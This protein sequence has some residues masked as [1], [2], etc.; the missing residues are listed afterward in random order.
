MSSELVM[1]DKSGNKEVIDFK[2]QDVVMLTA[3][4]AQLLAEEVDLLTEMKV[5]QIDSL[6]KE[7]ISVTIRID[8]CGG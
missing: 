7:K 1:T 8:C 2:A 4:L 5:K 3:R 6:Q